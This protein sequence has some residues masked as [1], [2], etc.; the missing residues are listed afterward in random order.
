[1]R[2]HLKFENPVSSRKEVVQTSRSY[3]QLLICFPVW[4]CSYPSP[5]LHIPGLVQDLQGFQQLPCSQQRE[6]DGPSRTSS[7]TLTVCFVRL[8]CDWKVNILLSGFGTQLFW[9]WVLAN[10]H[11]LS[12]NLCQP[13][14]QSSLWCLFALLLWPSFQST[15]YSPLPKKLFV[16]S[17]ITF[18]MQVD[19]SSLFWMCL[20]LVQPAS[21]PGCC[22]LSVETGGYRRGSKGVPQGQWMVQ[23]MK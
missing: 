8:L 7:N 12:K 10:R 4:R 23:L 14:A 15:I 2:S 19:A 9:L 20:F 18:C 17:L 6:S 22:L 13:S 3:P 5:V 11:F 21:F 1:M 16:C